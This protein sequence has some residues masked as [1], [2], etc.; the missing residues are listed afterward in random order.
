MD[1]GLGIAGL[2]FA[3]I[4]LF[5]PFGIVLSAVAI[6]LTS[7]AALAGDRPFTIA[8]LAI[9]AVN[10][11]LL[12][13]STWIFMQEPAFVLGVIVAAALPIVAIALNAS[14]TVKLGG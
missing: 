2:V 5:F 11:F 4:A 7:I 13:P 12:S 14:G 8:T 9:A 1:K 10:T 6:L 3:I